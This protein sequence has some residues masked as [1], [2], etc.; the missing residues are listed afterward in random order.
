M[1]PSENAKFQP[2]DFRAEK[3]RPLRSDKGACD[4]SA[5]RVTS[6]ESPVGEMGFFFFSQWLTIS[7]S[8]S[9]SKRSRG[10]KC[11]SFNLGP[12]RGKTV[13]VGPLCPC[14]L[15]YLPYK[16][17]SFLQMKELRHRDLLPEGTL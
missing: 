6:P 17:R 9:F 2:L 8:P 15:A 16:R 10:Q 3:E 1:E 7:S 11:Y 5:S 13:L 12:R 4:G 14:S